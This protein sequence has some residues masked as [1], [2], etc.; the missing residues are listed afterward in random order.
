M[1]RRTWEDKIRDRTSRGVEPYDFRRTYANWLE[2]AGIPRT[3]RK[4]YLGHGASDV[5]ALY[6]LHEVAAFL[7]EDA[8]KL[9]TFLGLSHTKVHT[10]TLSKAEGAP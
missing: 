7:V 1:H 9:S 8:A 5:T 2:A 3:R 4:L 6:E 10:M